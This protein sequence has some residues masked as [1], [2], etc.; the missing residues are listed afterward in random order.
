MQA[1]ASAEMATP[2]ELRPLDI[3]PV[4]TGRAST[5]APS[6][7]GFDE[8]LSQLADLVAA[9]VIDKLARPDN[10]AGDDWL[11]TRGASE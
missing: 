4:T 2:A 6:G 9:R 5:T 8:L 10:A 11:D 7:F 3:R 1:Y